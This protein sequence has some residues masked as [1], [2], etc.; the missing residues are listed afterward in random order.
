MFWIFYVISVAY[1]IYHLSKRWNR[2]VM[3]G[4]LGINPGLDTLAVLFLAPVLMVVDVTLTWIRIYKE[5][6]E[7]RRKRDKIY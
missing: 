5:A 6:E 3:P 7:A 1:C 4:G 2:D